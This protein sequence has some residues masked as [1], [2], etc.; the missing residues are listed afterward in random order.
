M[1]L[2]MSEF[3]NNMVRYNLWLI[4]SNLEVIPRVVYYSEIIYV[5]RGMPRNFGNA[6]FFGFAI[7]R[8]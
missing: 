3:F 2:L 6:F 8:K 7:N 1:I 4:E 5:I